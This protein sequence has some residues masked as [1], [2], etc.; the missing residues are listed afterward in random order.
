MNLTSRI[1]L[2]DD[3]AEALRCRFGRVRTLEDLVRLLG[4]VQ[5]RAALE[6]VVTQDEYTHD[7]IVRWAPHYLVFDTT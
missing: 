3:E 2:T 1:P 6:E 4:A 7:V 5:P